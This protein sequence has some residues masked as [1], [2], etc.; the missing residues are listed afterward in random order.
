MKTSSIT[1]KSQPMSC[2]ESIISGEKSE[3]SMSETTEVILATVFGYILCKLCVYD[4]ERIRVT[5]L[6][7]VEA[8]IAQNGQGYEETNLSSV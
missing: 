6:I 3:E 2:L 8:E 1:E 5:L 7:F 4:L